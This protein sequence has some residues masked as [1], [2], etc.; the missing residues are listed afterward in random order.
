MM[1]LTVYPRHVK[2]KFQEEYL[3]GISGL[4]AIEKPFNVVKIQ[5]Y[6]DVK[7]IGSMASQQARRK[8]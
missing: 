2:L 6:M 4:E 1:S 8:S 5:Y 7:E 3:K